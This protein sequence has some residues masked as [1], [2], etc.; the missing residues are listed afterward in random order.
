MHGQLDELLDYARM[1][2]GR[3]KLKTEPVD[4]ST[5]IPETLSFFQ[6]I[7]ERG[8]LRLVLDLPEHLPEL[9]VD[10]DRLRQILNNLVSNAIKYTPP[11]GTVTVRA[12]PHDDQITL[13]VQDTGIGLSPDDRAHL[14]EKFFR[15]SRPEVQDVP[16]SGIG[17]ALVKG[18]VEAH[19]GHIEAEG[20]PGKGS[21][22]RVTLPI[23]P[24]ADTGAPA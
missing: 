17:L 16:G 24:P 21:L 7:A 4:L 3:F 15:S 20:A 23:H 8:G 9:H 6:P 12:R 19:G 5:T 2:V 1:E 18:V 22:F 14:F 10:P 13:E 11:G